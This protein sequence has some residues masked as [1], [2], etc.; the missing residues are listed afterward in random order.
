MGAFKSSIGTVP[1]TA[2]LAICIFHA[3]DPKE[4]CML[5]CDQRTASQCHD[6][7]GGDHGTER[8]GKG[9]DTTG[10]PHLDIFLTF[11][12]SV[13]ASVKFPFDSHLLYVG[14]LVRREIDEGVISQLQLI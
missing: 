13:T 14:S 2:T 12:D 11:I 3:R 1:E 9:A 10:I 8:M 4:W 7:G 6:A 5:P